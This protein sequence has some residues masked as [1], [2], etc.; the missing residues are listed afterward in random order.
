MASNYVVVFFYFLLA[1]VL[2]FISVCLREDWQFCLAPV[3]SFHICNCLQGKTL[4]LRKISVID[5]SVHVAVGLQLL[6]ISSITK[7]NQTIWNV[8]TG[9]FFKVLF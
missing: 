1:C 2:M 9:T 7:L 4:S 8:C 6:E 5:E 3:K